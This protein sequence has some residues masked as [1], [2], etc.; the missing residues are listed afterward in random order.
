MKIQIIGYAGSG[1]STLA[2]KLGE[3]YNIPVIHL[4]NVKFYGN[5]QER[6]NEEQT[7]ILQ[8]FL[9]KNEDW[10]IDGNYS[11]ICPQRF[12]QSD[13]TI[14]MNFNRFF[15]FWSAYKR[16][17]KHRFA[18][19][20]SCPCNDKFDRAFKNWILFN[21]R[22]KARREKIYDNYN[23]TSGQKYMFKHRRQVNKFLESLEKERI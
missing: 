7:A 1:K 2:R 6:T 13:V 11:K 9:D 3:F 10:V 19:R 17:R 20:E 21:S 23:K 15:C 18:P 8:D 5:W 22:T 16:Y 14:F 4:D 12:E